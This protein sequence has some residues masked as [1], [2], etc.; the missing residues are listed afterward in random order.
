VGPPALKPTTS[1]TGFSGYGCARAAEIQIWTRHEVI[2]QMLRMDLRG[3]ACPLVPLLYCD[4]AV[5]VEK[6]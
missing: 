4:R 1:R 6:S 3:G 5:A 2:L